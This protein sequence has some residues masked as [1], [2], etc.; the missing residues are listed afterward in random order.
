MIEWQERLYNLRDIV[1]LTLYLLCFKI[2]W[3][4][5][6]L[7]TKCLKIGFKRKDSQNGWMSEWWDEFID[8]EPYLGA[9]ETTWEKNGGWIKL[10]LQEEGRYYVD[11]IT[12]V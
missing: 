8:E 10:G 5:T 1:I 2:C 6:S 12:D 11:W 4:I 7:I 3:R 9:W